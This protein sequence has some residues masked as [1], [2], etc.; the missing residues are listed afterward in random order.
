[1]RRSTCAVFLLVAPVVF[2]A[3][4]IKQDVR[5]LRLVD[6]AD[7]AICIREN[8]A[9]REGFLQA[10]RTRVESKGFTVT[11]LDRNAAV[12]DKSTS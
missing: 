9:V 8:P 7:R 5:P 2:A 6:G 3:C 11:L 4:S 1:V 12:K 10:Y